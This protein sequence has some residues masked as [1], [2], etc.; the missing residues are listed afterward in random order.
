MVKCSQITEH[1][2]KSFMHNSIYASTFWL[3]PSHL[4]PVLIRLYIG[5]FRLLF[6]CSRIQFAYVTFG[7]HRRNGLAFDT[8]KYDEKVEHLTRLSRLGP[9]VAKVNFQLHK[10]RQRHPM[11]FT[12]AYFTLLI[13]NHFHSLKFIK[14]F[15][16][17]QH[18]KRERLHTAKPFL[19]SSRLWKKAAATQQY[20]LHKVNVWHSHAIFSVRA[21]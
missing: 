18:S 7:W 14:L 6:V 19:F 15:C 12:A 1:I 4:G 21:K 9:S 20:C 5:K 13:I 17:H 10:H 11:T 2:E 8:F 16:H 3:L